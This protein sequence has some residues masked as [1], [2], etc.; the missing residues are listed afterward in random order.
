MTQQKTRATTLQQKF[1]FQ[2]ND[3]STPA[4]DALMV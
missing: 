1:G 2:D 4:H 3:L